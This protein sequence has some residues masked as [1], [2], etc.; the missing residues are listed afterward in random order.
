MCGAFKA[1]E[2]R[3]REHNDHK[4]LTIPGNHD[5][6]SLHSKKAGRNRNTPLYPV[7]IVPPGLRLTGQ[8][9]TGIGQCP[10]RW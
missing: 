5:G 1:K 8:N 6:P 2:H 9:P 7:L 3:E 10:D 4:V